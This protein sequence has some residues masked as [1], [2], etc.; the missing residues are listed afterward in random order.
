MNN[1][2]SIEFVLHGK[3]AGVDITPKTI[4]LAQF[5]EFNQQ[6]EAFI[7][8]SAKLKLDDAHVE[9]FQSSYVLRVLLPIVVATSLETDLK[10]MAKEDVL[11]RTGLQARGN[12]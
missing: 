6:V 2:P 1:T 8:G 7:S 4:G 9:I 11:G 5:N 10:L 12:H 3:V